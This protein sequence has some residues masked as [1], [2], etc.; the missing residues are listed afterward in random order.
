[1][2]AAALPQA[3]IRARM[4]RMYRPQTLV[5]DL[6]R[7]YYLLGRDRLIDGLDARPGE[8]VLEVGCGTGR[9]LVRIGRRYPGVALLGV[10]AAAPMLATARRALRRNRLAGRARLARG[11][12]ER[13]DLE[14]LFRLARPADHVVD[15]LH[16]L[17]GRRPGGGRSRPRSGRCGPAGGCTWSTSATAPACRVGRGTCS[18]PG[19]AASASA[20]GPRSRRRSTGSRPRASA[21][22]RRE[23]LAGRYA[24]LHRFTKAAA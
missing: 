1:M 6:T 15:L 3:D 7:K 11:V 19:C 17:H 18:R 10:D 14:A 23:D 8:I 21:E 24:V 2:R 16:A 9:N 12:A 13:L 22:H 5:Y 20:T 4:D